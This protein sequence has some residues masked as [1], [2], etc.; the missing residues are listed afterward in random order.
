MTRNYDVLI[1]SGKKDNYKLPWVIESLKWLNPQP[2]NIYIVSPDGVLP[3]SV[4]YG[5]ILHAVKDKDV[6]PGFDWKRIKHRPN[7]CTTCLMAL[8]QD[9]TDNDLYLDVQ[10]DNIFLEE[11]DLFT[12][13]KPNFFLSPQ[14]KGYHQPYFTFSLK[15]FNLAKDPENQDSFIVEFV[16]YNKRITRELIARYDSINDFLDYAVTI[17]DKDCYPGDQEVHGNWCMQNH[18]NKHEFLY[19]IKTIFEWKGHPDKWTISE[20]ERHIKKKK[21]KGAVAASFHSYLPP[22]SMLK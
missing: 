18:F 15:A 14:H 22:E 5:S 10:S 9:V 1:K 20:I 16:M 4:R 11:I 12:G 2:Q 8:F 13:N 19:N 21:N 3:N 6:F 7:W 17:I